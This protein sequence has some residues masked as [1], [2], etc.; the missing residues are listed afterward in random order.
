MCATYAAQLAARLALDETAQNWPREPK[1]I[2]RQ[3]AAI[4]PTAWRSQ[5]PFVYLNWIIRE[6]FK[7]E[8]KGGWPIEASSFGELSESLRIFE[9]YKTKLVSD[10]RDINKYDYGAIL[11]FAQIRRSQLNDRIASVYGEAPERVMK[12]TTLIYAGEEGLALSPHSRRASAYWG[13]KTEWCTSYEVDGPDNKFHEY[14]CQGP[15]VIMMPIEPVIYQMHGKILKGDNNQDVLKTTIEFERLA[16]AVRAVNPELVKY[17]LTKKP[18]IDIDSEDEEWELNIYEAIKANPYN[19]ELIFSVIRQAENLSLVLGALEEERFEDADFALRAIPHNPAVFPHFNFK[20][21]VR[22][23]VMTA[24]LMG[25]IKNES[26]IPLRLQKEIPEPIK[27]EM[28]EKALE[29]DWTAISFAHD[30][31]V[32]L[33]IDRQMSILGRAMR[34]AKPEVVANCLHLF[35]ALRPEVFERNMSPQAGYEILRQKNCHLSSGSSMNCS[36]L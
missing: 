18:V 17:E 14:N 23:D 34:E 22:P 28:F 7:E 27:H 11:N 35:P 8:E 5:K 15:A 20:A 25:D 30:F 32:A 16:H 21:L 26:L 4:D 13:D 31:D 9:R 2:F 10:K 1:E 24:G 12:E 29:R 6:Y 33:D 36:P 19:E 3:F